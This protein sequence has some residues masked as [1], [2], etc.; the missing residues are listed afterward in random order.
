M[1]DFSNYSGYDRWLSV[2]T[3]G[4]ACPDALDGRDRRPPPVRGGV[5][6][7]Q[8]LEVLEIKAD[9]PFEHGS[10]GTK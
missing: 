7:E 10:A 3:E 8:I 9:N 6:S 1:F 2:F 5:S 4:P